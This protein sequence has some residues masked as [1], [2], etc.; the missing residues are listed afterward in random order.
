MGQ[1]NRFAIRNHKKRHHDPDLTGS[2][3]GDAIPVA[4]QP[5]D[6]A[7]NY[8]IASSIAE[9]NALLLKIMPNVLAPLGT[10]TVLV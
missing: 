9:G 8:S 6:L 7:A 5:F 10:M 3:R 4:E 2:R 1:S